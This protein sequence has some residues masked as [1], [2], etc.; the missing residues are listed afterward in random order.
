MPRRNTKPRNERQAHAR[1]R[2]LAAIAR[3]RREGLSLSAAAKT[4]G[5]H[6]STIKRYAGSALRQKCP[7]GHCRVT[8]SDRIARTLN[9]LTTTV[10]VR[11]SR[12]A[13]QIGE[14]MNAVKA[15]G[16]GDISKVARFRGKSFR[17]TDG[18]HKFI[19]E[20]AKLDEILD[21]DVLKFEGLYRSVQG[22]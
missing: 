2:A 3:M 13:S 1:E 7:G 12:T 18:I 4:E 16:R 22:D 5:T 11:S 10:T 14:Y 9:F 19:T 15:Y 20:P 17:A 21:A 6:T 8:R